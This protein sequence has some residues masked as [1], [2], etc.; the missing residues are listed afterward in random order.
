[1]FGHID[2]VK[3][4][5]AA[6]SDITWKN[7][8]GYTALQA[9]RQQNFTSVV[10]YLEERRAYNRSRTNSRQFS[11]I[12]CWSLTPINDYVDSYVRNTHMTYSTISDHIDWL[13]ILYILYTFIWTLNCYICFTKEQKK[14]EKIGVL[15]PNPNAININVAKSIKMLKCMS[16]FI[17]TSLLF[18][19]LSYS[20]N[21]F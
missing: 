10:E 12:N 19:K 16:K 3:Q 9:A 5:V 17:Y 18:Y 7:Q 15:P 4:L 11:R 8:S 2:C 20:V 14:W 21:F 1:M 6:G 13:N